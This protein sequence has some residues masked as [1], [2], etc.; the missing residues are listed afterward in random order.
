MDYNCRNRFNIY[1]SLN[2]ED[3]E[4]IGLRDIMTSKY[5]L[6]FAGSTRTIYAIITKD[7]DGENYLYVFY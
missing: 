7:N 1:G 5:A 2:L 3:V 6:F 4:A